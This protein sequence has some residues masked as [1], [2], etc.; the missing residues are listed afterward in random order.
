MSRGKKAFDEAWPLYQEALN[1]IQ[2][3]YPGDP[4]VVEDQ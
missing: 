3:R 1:D 2:S 4:P